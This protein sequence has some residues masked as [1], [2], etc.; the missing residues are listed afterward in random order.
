MKPVVDALAA[1]EEPQF[2]PDSNALVAKRWAM[3]VDI[4]KCKDDCTDCIAACHHV[5]N[6]PDFGNPKDE[7][8]WIWQE[9]YEH[10]FPGREH[11]YVEES[12]KHKPFMML[13]N[14]CDNP[15]CV[16]VCPTQATF[17]RDDGVVMMDM[18]RCIG[19]RF[20][21]VSCPFNV[22]KF[23]YN[24]WNPKLVKCT[25]CFDRQKEGKK[26][27]CVEACPTGA[28]VFGDLDDPQS[29]VARLAHAPGSFRLLER[30]K[31]GA[32]VYYRTERDWVRRLAEGG[33]AA[34]D[35]RSHG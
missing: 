14:H 3:V 34:G 9:E 5:H 17:R 6:V 24:E 29:E 26:P 23:E 11:E 25:M 32:K 28:I 2:L 1:G 33:T 7:I 4:Q 19:C 21:M 15:P 31:T 27:A 13:C 10:A 8:K 35:G 22:P 16:R 30:L 20:C 12:L 18:H